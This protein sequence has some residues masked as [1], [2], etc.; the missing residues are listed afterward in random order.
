MAVG[1]AVPEPSGSTPTE[2]VVLA[3]R[4]TPNCSVPVV[5]AVCDARAVMVGEPEQVGQVRVVPLIVIAYPLTPFVP[6]PICERPLFVELGDSE[7]SATLVPVAPAQLELVMP[8]VPVQKVRVSSTVAVTVIWLAVLAATVP[9]ST[10]V[11]Y[12]VSE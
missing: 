12:A 11:V 8:D 10:A 4:L 5:D 3:L 6:T 1:V 2:G 9:V 7:P